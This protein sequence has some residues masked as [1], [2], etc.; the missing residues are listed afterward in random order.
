MIPH[1]PFVLIPD[2]VTA[3]DLARDK[4]CLCVAVFC[5]SC[6]DDPVLQKSIGRLFNQMVSMRL[7]AKKGWFTTMDLLQALLVGLA[8]YGPHG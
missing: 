6:S 1:F 3:Q 4:P 7:L 5:V 8:W 2:T